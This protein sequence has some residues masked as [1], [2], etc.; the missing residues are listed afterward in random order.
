MNDV[1]ADLKRAAERKWRGNPAC[2][3]AGL[4]ARGAAEIERLRAFARD[5]M[6][7]WPMG[8][9]DGGDLQGIATRHGLLTPETRHERCGETCGCAEYADARE[10]AAGVEC[11]RKEP[12]LMKP[13]VGAMR[14][15]AAGGTSV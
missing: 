7:V 6:A 8:D 11:F 5:V 15:D 12:F 1:L 3:Q 2:Q 14:R 4:F 10:F 13:N 9:L